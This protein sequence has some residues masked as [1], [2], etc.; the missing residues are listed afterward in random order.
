MKS[1]FSFLHL[2]FFMTLFV[3]LT[4]CS[5]DDDNISDSGDD[6]NADRFTGLEIGNSSFEIPQA[7]TD[8]H[9]EFDYEGESQVESIRFEISPV[10][11]E[12]PGKGEVAW[13]VPDYEVP[14]SYYEGQINPHIHHHVYFDPENGKFPK[15]RP[16]VG[17][18]R[19][20][21]IVTESNGTE[22]SIA[23]EFNVVKKFEDIEIGHEG[24]VEEGSDDLHTE[25]GYNAGDNVV[26]DIRL[27]IW[28]VEWR[29]GQNVAPGE[30]DKVDHILPENMYKGQK[31][32][33]IHYH[34]PIEPEYPQ[35]DYWLNIYV[36][37]SGENEAIKLSL[38]FQVVE[39]GSLD[40]DGHDH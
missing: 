13:D 28:F 3:L 2:S 21:A 32:P 15:V 39:K 6:I 36:T 9:V 4:S 38:P 1:K 27:E 14:S 5:N 7:T 20:K 11:V 24:K 35:G 19:F 34:L 10:D 17:T 29:E 22:S 25:F 18:Y 23:R 40:G 16:A 12:S 31:N 37:E 8:L 26:E 33:F 30:W